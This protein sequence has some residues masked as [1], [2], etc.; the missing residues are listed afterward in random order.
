MS[1]HNLVRLTDTIT[2]DIWARSN[3]TQQAGIEFARTGCCARF[4]TEVS[5]WRDFGKLAGKSCRIPMHQ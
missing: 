1:P 5:D 2:A 3:Q 4:H